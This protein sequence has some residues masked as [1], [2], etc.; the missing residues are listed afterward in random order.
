[1]PQ[2]RLGGLWGSLSPSENQFLNPGSLNSRRCSEP[3]GAGLGL[4][5]GDVSP[6]GALT[7]TFLLLPLPCE[8]LAEF[9]RG[10]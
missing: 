3:K 10:S 7:A 2:W 9:G 6:G 5:Q 1:M 8:N 4:A